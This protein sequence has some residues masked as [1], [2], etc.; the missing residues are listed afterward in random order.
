MEFLLTVYGLL[1]LSVLAYV[2]SWAQSYRRLRHFDGPPLSS[3]DL[4]MLR[5]AS[6]GRLCEIY[7]EVCQKYGSLARIGPK[8]LVT[9]DPELIK[10]MSSARSAY[11]RSS[12]YSCLRLHP[13]LHNMFSTLDR[14]QHDDIKARTAAGYTSREVPNLEADIDE[15]IVVMQ[16]LIRKKYISTGSDT[17]LMDF[18]NLMSYLTLDIITKLAYGETFDWLSTDSDVFSFNKILHGKMQLMETIG[19]VEPLGVFF[20]SIPVRK[21]FGAK[22]TDPDGLGRL[23]ALAADLVNKR[24]GPDAKD[25]KDML[26]S[27]I[28]HG[29]SRE[30]CEGEILL[31]VGAGADTSACALKGIFLYAITAPPVYHRLQQEIDRGISE[32]RISTPITNAEGKALPYLQAVILEGLRLH[33]PVP[34][35]FTKQLYGSEDD[36]YQGKRIPVGTK[37]AQATRGL[38]NRKDIFGEDAALFR[39]ERWL[40]AGPE[41]R[42]EMENTV[43]LNWGYGRW[44]CAGKNVAWVE[45]NKI[46]VEILRYFDLQIAAPTKPWNTATFV[47]VQVSGMMVKVTLRPEQKAE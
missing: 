33:P 22:A 25:Q 47:T 39:P 45:L 16:D 10:R 2:I 28:R 6:S 42:D 14:D 20:G 19:E 3:T 36:Y 5:T 35:I 15:Q 21:I 29:L 8:T 17:K 44:G 38:M 37:I 1:G 40:E 31:Q 13:R 34:T 9:D 23:M 11:S 18:S 27:F 26:G 46:V 30:H 32:G 4:F 7:M 43:H 41:K 24:F 12:Y